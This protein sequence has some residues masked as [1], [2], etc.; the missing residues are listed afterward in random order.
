MPARKKKNR[1]PPLSNKEESN[2]KNMKYRD[3]NIQTQR[4][5]PNNARTEGFSFLVRAGYLTRE[6]TPTQLGVHTLDHLRGLAGDPSFFDTLALPTIGNEDETFFPIASGQIDVAH[7]PNCQYTERLELAQFKKV[8]FPKEDELPL[9]K[10]LTPDCHTI[11]ALADF[12]GMP[13]EK[14]AKATHVHTSQ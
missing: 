13:K 6:N 14:T 8:P 10:V 9:E 3:L 5:A 7:C 4:E 12:L 11:E 1:L 2:N